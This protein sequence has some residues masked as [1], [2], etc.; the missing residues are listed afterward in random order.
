M[1]LVT[2]S[3]DIKTPV[4]NVFTYF[5][6]PEHISDQIKT[7]VVGMTSRSYGYQRRNGCGYNF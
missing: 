5:A 6:R 4:E 3:I 1:T 7:D 2:K